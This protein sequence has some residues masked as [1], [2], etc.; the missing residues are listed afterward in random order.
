MTNAVRHLVVLGGGGSAGW[1]A[2][3]LLAA[4]HGG[5]EPG[6]L[7]AITL[8]ESPDTPAIGV[9]GRNRGPQLVTPS[10]LIRT[11]PIVRE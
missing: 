8:I 5:M 7:V 11:R 2:A 3:A 4:E 10:A 6:A 9:G 1:I